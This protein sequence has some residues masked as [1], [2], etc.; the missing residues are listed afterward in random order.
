M[1]KGEIWSDEDDREFYRLRN[2]GTSW[3]DMCEAFP[4][5]TLSALQAK[6][7]NDRHRTV[8][9]S[10]E[11]LVARLYGDARYTDNPMAAWTS[12]I[13]RPRFVRHSH[14]SMMTLGGVG[15][16]DMPM[17]SATRTRGGV[18]RA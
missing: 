14:H 17:M 7:Y 18:V 12:R 2:I 4:N 13:A 15:S 9:E 11:D 6:E 1:S 16:L 3:Q 8:F 10:H 5:R